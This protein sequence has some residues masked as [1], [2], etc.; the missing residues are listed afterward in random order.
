MRKRYLLTLTAL[1]VLAHPATAQTPDR[2]S[3][4]G[5]TIAVY[6]LA[7]AVTIERGTGADVVV[8]VTRGGRDG[9][10]LELE[11][12]DVDNRPALVVRYPDDDVV[13]DGPGG[14]STQMTVRADGTFGNGARGDRVTIRR[15]GNGTHAHANLR[16]LVPAGR[17]VDVHLGVGEVA[18][19]DIAGDL[20]IDVHSAA[21]RTRGTKG[22]LHIDTG[23][24]SVA[25]NDAEGDD[26]LIDTGSGSVEVNGIRASDLSVDTG[27]GRVTGGSIVATNVG[28]DTGSGSIVLT[29]VSATD[30]ELDTGSGR[31]ELDVVTQVEDLLVDTGSGGVSLTV[32]SNLNAS[33]EVETGS[34]GIDV[35]LPVTVSS[36]SRT[37]LSGR[38]GSGGGQIVIDTGSG[39]IS[40]RAR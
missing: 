18:A 27:S 5:S 12:M 15:S 23:S 20:S 16:I 7:G 38:L 11:R 22:Q 2:F 39:G 25:V 32:P 34:G 3:I 26:I 19:S 40:I 8:E 14:G 10:Q 37:S 33:L 13:Y 1:T 24:G 29:N 36:R 6:N 9:A 21:V 30:I 28:V 35:E 31:I 4:P 17:A